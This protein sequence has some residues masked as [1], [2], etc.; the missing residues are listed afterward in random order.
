MFR[1]SIFCNRGVPTYKTICRPYYHLQYTEL[2][3][4]LQGMIYKHDYVKEIIKN[5]KLQQ[6]IYQINYKNFKYF[7]K[8]AHMNAVKM[9]TILK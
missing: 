5:I 9:I 6:S 3:W 2:W 4:D 8:I 7:F 1:A